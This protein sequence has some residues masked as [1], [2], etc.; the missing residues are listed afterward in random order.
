MCN[1]VSFLTDVQVCWHVV[2]STRA[3]VR[4][5]YWDVHNTT[6]NRISKWHCSVMPGRSVHNT[7][8]ISATLSI[9]R[10]HPSLAVAESFATSLEFVSNVYI[11]EGERIEFD[12]LEIQ[13]E[14]Y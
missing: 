5:R 12:D 4:A 11:M 3:V 13:L 9:T 14:L 2:S 1:D 8:S 6:H 7:V 10:E